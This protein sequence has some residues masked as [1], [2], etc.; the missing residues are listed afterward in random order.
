MRQAMILA[1][2]G[3]SYVAD[4]STAD[5]RSC[6][7]RPWEDPVNPFLDWGVEAPENVVLWQIMDC[8]NLQPEIPNDCML[9]TEGHDV[10][11]EVTIQGWETCE[12]PSD[13]LA[14]NLN[15]IFLVQFRPSQ[16]LSAGE[17]VFRC[18]GFRADLEPVVRV[19]DGG[20]P[21]AAPEQPQDLEVRRVDV[22]ET[23]GCREECIPDH[24]ELKFNFD[25]AYLD[26]G[27]YLEA[28][29]A[30][31][32]LAFVTRAAFDD[33]AILPT[34]PLPIRMTPVAADGTR[35]EPVEIRGDDISGTNETSECRVGGGVLSPNTFW[36][37]APLL[38]CWSRRRRS[39]TA[40]LPKLNKKDAEPPGAS[41]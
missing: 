22:A 41:A 26:E 6:P 12:I 16:L 25:A 19:R 17:Y 27:G 15:P 33:E 36:L 4:A 8:T 9:S 1:A 38:W 35:G 30:N 24:L 13:E 18:Q 31:G 39:S 5:A 11:L 20:V 10:P 14:D 23:K 28:M 7:R 3:F 40:R 21:A 29:F 2:F 34:G 32:Q 37:G